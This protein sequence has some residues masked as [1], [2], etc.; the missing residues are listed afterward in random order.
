MLL[1]ALTGQQCLQLCSSGCLCYRCMAMAQRG[2]M[3]IK[4]RCSSWKPQRANP[5][6][7]QRGVR[8]PDHD[9]TP[10]SS[11]SAAVSAHAAAGA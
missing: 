9:V 3:G 5:A 1:T 2:C 10:T 4:R 7:S 11:A 6:L 8:Q